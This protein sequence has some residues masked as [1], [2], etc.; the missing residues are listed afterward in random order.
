ME[1]SMSIGQG[2]MSK[3]IFWM[4]QSNISSCQDVSEQLCTSTSKVLQ[5]YVMVWH[6]L[7]SNRYT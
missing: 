2:K 5:Y 7:G 1:L 3:H 4:H 6:N